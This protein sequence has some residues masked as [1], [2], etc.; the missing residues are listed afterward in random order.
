MDKETLQALSQRLREQRKAF[1]KEFKEAETA[2]GFFA[3]DRESEIEQR[4]QGERAA[5][6]LACLDD[7][8]IRAVAEIDAALERISAGNYGKCQHCGKEIPVAR[9]RTVPA[10]RVCVECAGEGAK[11]PSAAPSLEIA[12]AAKSSG[13]LSLL[14]DTEL[15]AA[16]RE[17]IKEDG[18][19]DTE[20]LRIVCRRGVVH[21]Y[22]S[23]PSEEEHSIVLNLIT[24]VLGLQEVGDRVRVD[25]L[26]WERDERSKG[27]PPEKVL[28]W[29]ESLGT[30]DVVECAEEGKDFVPPSDP[31][32]EEK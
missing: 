28:P 7:R 22:G 23:L 10:T 17:R 8:S 19:V 2:L 26:S 16:I 11:K 13:D 24:D 31:T 25:E 9:L 18:R 6:F 15:E 1:L 3:E 27:K 12:A 29:E 14:S 30:E 5:R 20:E 21:L 4:A 32:P